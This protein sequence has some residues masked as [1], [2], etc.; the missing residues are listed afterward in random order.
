MD[1]SRLTLGVLRWQEEAQGAG[2]EMRNNGLRAT[3][4]RRYQS[5]L[6]IS[7]EKAWGLPP[8][9]TDKVPR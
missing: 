1:R 8:G 4:V 6:S 7:E 3:S 5:C 2:A 9:N